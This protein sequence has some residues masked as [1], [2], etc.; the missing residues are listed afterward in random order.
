[1][2]VAAVLGVAAPAQAATLLYDQDF[3]NPNSFN[4]SLDRDVDQR[5]VN[6][7][8]GNQPAGFTF[9]NNFTVETI[10]VTDS[11]RP[12]G[13]RSFGSIG[14]YFGDLS[15]AGNFVVGML[16][17]AQDDRLGL[18]F[19]ITGFDFLNIRIDLTNLDLDC[20]GAPFHTGNYDTTPD[21]QFSLF[22]EA[23]AGGLGGGAL[24]DQVVFSAPA[25]ARNEIDFTTVTFGLD[26]KQAT[27][28]IVTLQIDLLTGGYAA[29]D[30]LRI[31]AS[32]TEGDVGVV[33]LPAAGWLLLGGVAL[34]GAAGRRRRA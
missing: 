11:V 7:L 22:D 20:C 5:P 25:S 13:Q 14:G 21:F 12:G 34:L 9:A 27:D 29:F 23:G 18:T 1:M 10:N 4:P 28:G 26:A 6:T 30:N 19:D 16:S 31:A 2:G 32:D 17:T 3:E 15:R 33:P 8:Y 24:L